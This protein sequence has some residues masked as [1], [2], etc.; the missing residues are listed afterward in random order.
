MSRAVSV[1]KRHDS[2]SPVIQSGQLADVLFFVR[3]VQLGAVD[4]TF[5]LA[6]LKPIE[7]LMLI[8]RCSLALLRQALF[9]RRQPTG[10]RFL[11]VRN[12]NSA[13]GA[14]LVKTVPD[15]PDGHI[16]GISY[17]VVERQWQRRGIGTLLLQ[18]AIEDAPPRSGF[19]CFCTPKAKTMMRVLR[20]FGFRRRVRSGMVEGMVFPH[21]FELQRARGSSLPQSPAVVVRGGLM[22]G[23]NQAAIRRRPTGRARFARHVALQFVLA[24]LLA[25]CRP[26]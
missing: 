24:V 9:A 22:P 14:M 10:D 12:G 26:M 6:F 18:R 15:G 13:I 1:S 5:N 21:A 16:V 20:R 2:L 23:S 11:V 3:Q 17:L 4:G 19:V 7:Q 8:K 25:A